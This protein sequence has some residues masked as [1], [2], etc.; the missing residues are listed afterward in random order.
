M[1]KLPITLLSV[2]IGLSLL[3]CAP[4][5]RGGMVVNPKTGLQFGSV[6]EK[7]ILLDASQFENKKVKVRIRNTSGDRAFNLYQFKGKLNKAFESKGY[8]V[9]EVGNYGMLIDV[10][11]TY[12]GQVSR[13]LSKEFGFLGASA[14]GLSGA[15]IA[16]NKGIGAAAGILAGATLGSVVGSYVTE[17]TYIVVA[18]VSLGVAEARRGK[19][20]TTIVFGSSKKE[21]DEDSGFKPFRQRIT[22]GIAV[23][24]GGRNTPQHAIASEVRERFVRIISDVI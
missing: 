21:K 16:T 6:I 4:T 14:G 23:F 11:V 13:N 10:N 12:S 9:T 3:A 7:N 20:K 5:Q 15:S 2:F 24:A 19:K 8:L 17:D 22:T 18:N 1:K